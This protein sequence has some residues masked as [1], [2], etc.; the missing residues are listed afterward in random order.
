MIQCLLPVMMRAPSHRPKTYRTIEKG[1]PLLITVNIRGEGNVRIKCWHN[2]QKLYKERFSWLS[3]RQTKS[4][5]ANS[6]V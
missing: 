1:F 2:E 4:L 5:F 3:S 6:N